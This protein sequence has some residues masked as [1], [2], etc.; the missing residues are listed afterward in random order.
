MAMAQLASS[1]PSASASSGSASASSSAAAKSEIQ[2][3]LGQFDAQI[4]AMM[5]YPAKDTINALTML[6]ERT[7][8]APEIV[9][10]LETKIHRVNAH[11]H[12]PSSSLSRSHV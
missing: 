5:D 10:F 12:P 3:L 7:Q 4:N 1:T 9:S 11:T 6:A 2:S 8:F